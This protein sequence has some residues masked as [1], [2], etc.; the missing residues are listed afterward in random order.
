[1]RG[2]ARER[3]GA[4]FPRGTDAGPREPGEERMKA[5][6]AYLAEVMSA[7]YPQPCA[8]ANADVF[9]DGPLVAEFRAIPHARRPR[10]LVPASRRAAAAAMR[11]Y[12]RPESRSGLVK[13]R[14]A[15]LA[16]RTG[17]ASLLLRD[18]IQVARPPDTVAPDTIDRYLCE[19][20]GQELLLSVHMGRGRST[21][22]PVLQLLTPGGHTVGF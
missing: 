12:P 7:M 20:L 8:V 10:M 22:K 14:L 5:S 17:A 2:R 19:S 16:L 13:R 4:A 11:R 1:M 6:T 3:R 18:R 21:R 15:A 9:P